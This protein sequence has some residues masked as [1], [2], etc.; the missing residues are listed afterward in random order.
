MGDEC[1]SDPERVRETLVCDKH[2][3]KN[4]IENGKCYGYL[5]VD[6]EYGCTPAERDVILVLTES[7]LQLMENLSH[8]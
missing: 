2:E 3:N 8:H 7:S 5:K 6:V 1:E 4:F